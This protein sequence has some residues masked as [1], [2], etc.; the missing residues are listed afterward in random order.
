MAA[1]GP[2]QMRV[3]RMGIGFVDPPPAEMRDA[4]LVYFATHS[5]VYDNRYPMK[6][7]EVWEAGHVLMDKPLI[8]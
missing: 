5:D 4:F 6:P 1:L 8:R 2:G 7:R 3:E